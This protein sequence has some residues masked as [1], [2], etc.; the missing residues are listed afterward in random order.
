MRALYDLA[1]KIPSF[2]FFS[3]L[4]MAKAL[5]ASKIVIDASYPKTDKW[6]ELQ[7]MERVRS[8]LLPGAALAGLPVVEGANGEDVAG[9]RIEDLVQFMAVG[10]RI[11]RLRTVLQPGMARYTVT[12]RKTQRA[13]GRDS[14]ESAWRAFAA[15]IG[16]LT[17]ED[18]DARPIG[19]HERMALY[20]GA[21][22]NFFVNS[23]PSHLCVLGG[24]PA[25]IFCGHV[26]T[27]L[28][29]RCGLPVGGKWPWMTRGQYLIWEPDEL[30]VLRRN[31]KEWHERAA[32]F[33]RV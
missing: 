25:M 21:E 23:G 33:H 7:V 4:V 5:G 27:S 14:N 3:W 30:P 11:E 9:A 12:L 19:L 28:F 26:C 24:Y 22:M 31:F 29:R 17:I 32:D 13:P 16:A 6:P 15:D 10:R 1:R 18:Y 2:D 8:I 20:A